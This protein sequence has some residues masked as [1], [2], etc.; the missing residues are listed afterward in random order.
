LQGTKNSEPEIPLEKLEQLRAEGEL[1]LIEYLKE[2][3][4][5]SEPALRRALTEKDQLKPVQ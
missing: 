4:K 5:R 3:T 2:E 1:P